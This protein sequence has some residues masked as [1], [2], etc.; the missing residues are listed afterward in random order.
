MAK[1]QDLAVALRSTMGKA[2]KNLRKKGII[3][4]NISGH[5]QESVAVQVESGAFD[6]LRRSGGTTRPA[7]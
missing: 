3:P 7:R 1:Q 4:G 2:N 5:N 6:I